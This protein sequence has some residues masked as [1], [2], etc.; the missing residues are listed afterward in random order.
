MSIHTAWSQQIE[1]Q[2]NGMI[3][4]GN[5]TN[6]PMPSDHTL[7]DATPVSGTRIHT[8]KLT[9]TGNQG[10][11]VE[12]IRTNSSSFAVE[13]RIGRLAGNETKTF[14]ISFEP[15]STG[16]FN[17][18]VW[19]RVKIGRSRMVYGF[20]IAGIATDA[21]G[22]SELMITQYYENGSDDVVEI[23]NLTNYDIK[24]N[25]YHLVKFNRNDDL[26]SPPRSQNTVSIGRLEPGEA[27]VFNELN[28]RGN[29]VVIISTSKGRNSYRDRIDIIGEQRLWG[30][31]LSFSK[32]ACASEQ[33]HTSFN[34][35][36]WI[37][38]AVEKVDQALSIQNIALG[39]YQ[40][41]PI[42]W[43]NSGWTGNALPDQTREVFIEAAYQGDIRSIEACDLTINALLDFNYNN[44][45]SVIV[46]KNLFINDSFILG[47]TE[48]MV[49]YD[50]NAQITGEIQKIEKSTYRN[51]AYD[52]TYWSS[53]I[54]NPL[55]SAVFTEVNANRLY[56]Y[57]QSQTTT[58]DKNHPDFW[59]TWLLASGTMQNG[60]GYAA[61]GKTGTTGIH[62]IQ[63]IG[64]PNNG[65][66]YKEL[67]FHDD[68]DVNS[69]LN[70]DFNMLGNPYPSAID[71]EVFF[72]LNAA[73]IEPT[74]YLWTHAT[75]IDGESGDYSFDDY[76][77]YNYLGGTSIALPGNGGV[78][79]TKNI[80]SSQ[81]F[82]V[83]ARSEGSVLFNNSMRMENAND[84]F[85]KGLIRKDKKQMADKDRIWLNLTTNKGG[86]NQLLI[87]FDADATDGF[88]SGYDAL[89]F[90]GSN[91]IGFYSLLEEDKLTIQ[92]LGSFTTDKKL[93]LGFDTKV[94]N[95]QY[96][97]SISKMEGKLREAT[98]ILRD[99]LLMLDHD[100]KDA[101]YIFDHQKNGEYKD[102]FTL[103]FLHAFPVTDQVAEENDS[104]VVTN[105]EDVFT[106][107]STDEVATASVFDI[108]GRQVKII[109][110]NDNSFE[111]IESESKKG[112]IL[113]LQLEMRDQ[114]R[115][116]KK[117]YKQ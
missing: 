1:I 90:N 9:N 86:F 58:S 77:S 19:F 42:S 67:D 63:F 47:D 26:D 27:V 56:Y 33:A 96:K 97:I 18:F 39:M 92:G 91:K 49:M 98:I 69:D 85:F 4:P 25:E 110:P 52:F 13:G 3:I 73:T 88:D 99:N 102:R 81:G 70:N 59:S 57:D 103:R 28:L 61:E 14:D 24:Q 105:E 87:G 34:I 82:F 75:P 60:M 16:D 113:L 107:T 106:V 100:L 46:Y 68:D 48:S 6:T 94:D 101:P 43:T 35:E 45:N 80:G 32:G 114:K 23:K 71:I 109:Y 83:R 116:V 95:R 15:T 29:E 89:K 112:E 53:P 79:P 93:T 31:G 51:N 44:T 11:T 50:D 65:V 55:L 78:V 30:R 20:R 17:A 22:E 111:F 12:S 72:E 117:L 2:G 84:Q 76:A 115:I 7:F 8:F 66:I 108:R 62:Q 38:L 21:T 54:D 40:A 37:E 10:V 5:W 64:K 36:D 41:G 74:V 104:I